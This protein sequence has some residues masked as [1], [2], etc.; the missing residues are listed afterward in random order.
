MCMSARE[1]SYIQCLYE[2]P[3]LSFCYAHITREGTEARQRLLF[4][5]FFET[6]HVEFLLQSIYIGLDDLIGPTFFEKKRL[7]LWLSGGN[8]VFSPEI[9][10]K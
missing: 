8:L 1:K 5:V 3:D 2:W 7:K 10:R 9:I 6:S 4:A